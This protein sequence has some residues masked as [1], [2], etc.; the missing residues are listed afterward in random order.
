MLLHKT[1][2]HDSRVRREASTLVEAGYAVTVLELA[3]VP[4]AER[5]LDGFSRRSAMPPGWVRRALPFHAYR[6]VFLLSFLANVVRLRPDIIHAHDAAMLLP[7]LVG[8]RLTG[9]RLVYDSHELATS[10]PYREKAWAWFVGAIE[11]LAVPRAALVITV[12]DGIADRLRDRYGLSGTPVVVRNVSALVEAEPGGSAPGLRERLGLGP[13]TPLVLHQGAAAPMR[14]CTTLVRAVAALDDAHLVFLGDDDVRGFNGELAQ[15]AS[16]LGA[17]DR[18]HFA[19]SQPL[20]RLLALTREADV[21]VTLL[22][23]TCVNHQLALPNKLFEYVAAGIPVVAS[24]LPEMGALVRERHI[25]WTA[26]PSD[27]EAVAGALRV[28]LAAGHLEPLRARL[29]EAE[30]ELRWPV[31]RRRLLDAYARLAART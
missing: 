5:T 18:V 22:E 1:V 4:A 27:P 31:E 14:G 11:R 13:R 7:G 10:V 20:E 30:A 3:P 16:G 15:L 2:V 26:D 8:A 24:D 6:A 17:G 25:G 21:G 29:R 12:S 23:D 9:A 28:A 19:A